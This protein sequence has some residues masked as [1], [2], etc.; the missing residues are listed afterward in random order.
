MT[1]LKSLNGKVL[2]SRIDGA[3]FSAKIPFNPNDFN[4]RIK[5]NNI[6]DS[7]DTTNFSTLI[8]FYKKHLLKTFNLNDNAVKNTENGIKIIETK[9]IGIY[10]ELK[11]IN[12][13]LSITIQFK[14]F[15]FIQDNALHKM[16]LFLTDLISYTKVFFRLTLIDIAKDVT[17]KPDEIL[18]YDPIVLNKESFKYMFS[19]K[20]DIYSEQKNNEQYE[21]VLD[22]KTQD[23]ISKFTIR[24]LKTRNR[25][26]ALKRSIMNNTFL[27]IWIMKVTKLLSQG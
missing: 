4:Q 1:K 24:C 11:R 25:I 16:R 18:P 10:C 22:F 8:N 21:T 7:T 26:M 2:R 12:Y 23:L 27:S 19:H 15:F 9:N 13:D 6:E 3:N 5:I 14:G 17:M 20:K